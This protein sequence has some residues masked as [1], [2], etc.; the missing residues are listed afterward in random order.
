MGTI[1]LVTLVAAYKNM[2]LKVQIQKDLKKVKALI[3]LCRKSSK[4][5]AKDNLL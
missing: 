2:E 1:F 3:S 5:L 4:F